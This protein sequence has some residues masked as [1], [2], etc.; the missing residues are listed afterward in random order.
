MELVTIGL[1]LL[2]NTC[3]KNQAVNGAIDDFVTGSV[4]WV[5]GWFGKTNKQDIV[6]KL[7][8]NPTSP[9]AQAEVSD[10]L[11]KLIENNQFKEEFEK[12]IVESKKPNPSMNNVIT[13]KNVIEGANLDI[14]GNIKIGDKGDGKSDYDEK[15]ILKDV[16]IKGGGDFTL[17]DG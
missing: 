9:E 8:A 11:T 7:Q 2:V 4:K 5:K 12:W 17:G 10:T 14:G 15:N 13:K 1:G 16:T 3:V 6:Q